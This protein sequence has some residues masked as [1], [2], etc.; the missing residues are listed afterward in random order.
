MSLQN[1]IQDCFDDYEFNKEKMILEARL[2]KVIQNLTKEELLTKWNKGQKEHRE[3]R[4]FDINSEDWEDCL[5]DEVLDSFWY[6][7]II[8]VKESVTAK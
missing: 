1:K 5:K 3:E 7:R 2:N 8:N 6:S 4:E